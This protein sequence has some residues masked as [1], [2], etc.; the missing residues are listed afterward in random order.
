LIKK[1]NLTS[2]G[3]L[4]TPKF[5]PTGNTVTGGA[6]IGLKKREILRKKGVLNTH[7]AVDRLR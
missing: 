1:Q 4:S 7:A 2:C 3:F 5:Y 6:L